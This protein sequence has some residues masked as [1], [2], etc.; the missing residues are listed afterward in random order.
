MLGKV[1]KPRNRKKFYEMQNIEKRRQAE[2]TL[3]D[4]RKHMVTIQPDHDLYVHLGM[5]ELLVGQPGNAL[6]AAKQAICFNEVSYLAWYV[7]GCAHLD[8]RE[9]T[10]AQS[11]YEEAV[12]L[13]PQDMPKK[14]D[15]GIME[16]L[17]D[18]LQIIETLKV[19][20]SKKSK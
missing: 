14:L 12:R 1:I 15:R 11:A 8:M 19:N 10:S 4:I 3:V 2:R 7:L 18:S 6:K 5:A 16:D 17:F 13:H 20:K 9:L